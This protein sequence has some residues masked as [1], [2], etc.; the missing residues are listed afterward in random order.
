MG[1]SLVRDGA[2]MM[3]NFYCTHE[4]KVIGYCDAISESGCEV[5][6]YEGLRVNPR[7]MIAGLII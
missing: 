3:F 4:K 2:V 7:S 1:G 5:P 6:V